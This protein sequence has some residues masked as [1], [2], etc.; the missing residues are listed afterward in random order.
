M[1]APVI[2]SEL[3]EAEIFEGDGG[4]KIKTEQKEC[5]GMEAARVHQ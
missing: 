2:G 5:T 3:W 1:C 4:R